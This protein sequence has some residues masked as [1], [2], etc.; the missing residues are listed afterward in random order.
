MESKVI[1]EGVKDCDAH[2]WCA[3]E[4]CGCQGAVCTYCLA[5]R[6]TDGDSE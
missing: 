4:A 1:L 3:E 6:E 5:V 2:D